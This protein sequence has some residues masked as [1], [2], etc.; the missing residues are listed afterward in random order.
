MENE[1]TVST[2]DELVTALGGTPAEEP[3]DQVETSSEETQATEEEHKEED[4]ST[5]QEASKEEENAGAAYN[6]QQQA[7]IHMRQENKRQ[8]DLLKG[9][10]ELLGVDTHDDT[11]LLEA[12]Q[13]KI[14]ESQAQKQNVPVELLQRM[15]VLEAQNRAYHAEQRQRDLA[16]GMQ[17]VMTTFNLNQEQLNKFAQ[18][19]IKE[20][21][22]PLEK[23]VDFV[24][25]YKLMH[26]DEVVN[27]AREDAVAAEQARAAKA[28][29]SSSK[30]GKKTGGPEQGAD[31]QKVNSVRD[32]E[33]WFKNNS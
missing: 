25:E 32:L 28:A 18:D 13:Y 33:A 6:K 12:L 10:A 2:V 4:N 23:E 3:E 30:P 9:V 21:I 8:S 14:T 31:D 19:L 5:A 15:N 16:I 27:K 29:N 20:G 24:R 1:N 17:R 7:F 26:F 22:N 11:K